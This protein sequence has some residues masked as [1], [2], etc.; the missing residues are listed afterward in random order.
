MA[1]IARL[2]K[3][4]SRKTLASIAME[5]PAPVVRNFVGIML[6]KNLQDG[7]FRR[8]RII[9]MLLCG[10]ILLLRLLVYSS[11]WHPSVLTC[12]AKLMCR[13]KIHSKPRGAHL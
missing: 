13:F 11:N 10:V 6:Y 9:L 4:Q 2:R 12:R 8:I 5:V 3:E 1:F 7:T